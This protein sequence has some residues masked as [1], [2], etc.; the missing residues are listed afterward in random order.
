MHDR[1]YVSRGE[2]LPLALEELNA[3]WLGRLLQLEYPGVVVNEMTLVRLIQGHTTKARLELHLNQAGVDAGLPSQVCLKANLTGDPL[4]SEVC[5]NE[6]RF[7][8]TLRS[9]LELPAPRCYFADWDDDRDGRQ[10]IVVLEDLVPLGGSFGT[11][12]QPIGV[13]DAAQS[14]LGLAALHGKTWNHPELRRHNWL[15]TAMAPETSTDDYWG[16]M[17]QYAADFNSLRE[18]LAVLPEWIA[19]NPQRLRAAFQQLC[20]EETSNTGPLCLVHGDAHLGNSYRHPNGERIWFDWQI[21]R[22][23]R[24]MR[25]YTYFVVGSMP[26]EDRRRAERDL[27][28]QYCEALASHGIHLEYDG[29]WR[30]YRRWIIWGIIAWQLNINPNEA[31]MPTLERFCRAAEDLEV[32]KLFR[33]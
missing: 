25:D 30:D 19:E 26:I 24:P 33:V 31:T 10:G 15:Q 6:A 3:Q 20:A 28:K 13:D 14:V 16:L 4:S 17:P 5:V 1:G 29:A 32:R 22:K 21:V 23:G 18:R 2:R 12:A 8:R 27:L 11:S 9:R 7:Y